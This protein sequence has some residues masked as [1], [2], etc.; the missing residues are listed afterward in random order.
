MDEGAYAAVGKSCYRRVVKG[1]MAVSYLLPTAE[2]RM[3]SRIREKSMQTVLSSD[4][5]ETGA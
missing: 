4:G 2:S 1:V 3:S 5:D